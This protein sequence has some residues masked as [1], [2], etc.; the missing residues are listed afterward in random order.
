V[1]E[2]KIFALLDKNND[3]FIQRSELIEGF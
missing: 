2:R 1:L 3:G